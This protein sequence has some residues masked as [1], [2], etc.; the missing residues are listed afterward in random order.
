MP[1]QKNEGEKRHRKSSSNIYLS[2]SPTCQKIPAPSDL[3]M[4][5]TALGQTRS[6]SVHHQCLNES[7]CFTKCL[8]KPK[9]RGLLLD[10]FP[11]SSVSISVAGVGCQAIILRILFII[12][13]R[14]QQQ[15]CI[16]PYVFGLACHSQT[17]GI[18]VCV[19]GQIY[20][21]PIRILNKM[22]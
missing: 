3:L 5:T 11:I 4:E 13:Q 16:F 7:F 2:H 22:K 6:T 12:L 18:T 1:P 19:C 15:G 10:C 17:A 21:E 20:C 8:S 14:F 9:S